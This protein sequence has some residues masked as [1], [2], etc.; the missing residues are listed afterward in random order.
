[1]RSGGAAG[2]L[3]IPAGSKVR[4]AA[5]L[6]CIAASA[7]SPT[8]AA[9]L[10][11]ALVLAGTPHGGGDASDGR[12]RPPGLSFALAYLM[13]AVAVGALFLAAP[14]AGL[15]AFLLLSAWH[16]AAE[17]P[18]DAFVR[19]GHGLLPVG[20]GAL[21]QG[22]A[23]AGVFGAIANA[24]IPPAMMAALAAAGAIGCAAWAV[25][26]ARRGMPAFD[27]VVVVAAFALLPPVLAVAFYFGLVHGPAAT[28]RM[29]D[30][31]GLAATRRALTATG[32]AGMLAVTGLT[33]AWWAGLLPVWLVAAILVGFAVPHMIADVDAA[34]WRRPAPSRPKIN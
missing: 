3:A 18:G 26:V 33:V 16:F 28:G 12:L 6:L 19:A 5:L 14:V 23:T 7:A 17:M 10:A 22:T 21:F 13:R 25:A 4:A 30:A 29:I 11:L 32:I 9:L 20:G 34:P 1:M 8:L 24:P 2:A 15:L 31:H 27:A